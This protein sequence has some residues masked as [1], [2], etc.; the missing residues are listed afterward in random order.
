[1]MGF[2]QVVVLKQQ[3]LGLYYLFIYLFWPHGVLRFE[4]CSRSKGKRRFHCLF[5]FLISS[6]RNPAIDCCKYLLIRCRGP[7]LSDAC[8]SDVLWRMPVCFLRPPEEFFDK[9]LCMCTAQRPTWCND[10]RFS[11][12]EEWESCLFLCWPRLPNQETLIR[13]WVTACLRGHWDSTKLLAHCLFL[14]DKIRTFL[15]SQQI[16]IRRSEKGCW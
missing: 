8:V 9:C 4:L 5:A 7:S 6:H 14:L 10:S 1:M 13:P 16:S 2:K 3:I 15:W 12:S 11:G